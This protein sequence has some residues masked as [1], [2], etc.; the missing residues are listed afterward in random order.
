MYFL[1]IVYMGVVVYYVYILLNIII[2]KVVFCVIMLNIYFNL[3]N[4]MSFIIGCMENLLEG[5]CYWIVLVSLRV[6]MCK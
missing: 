6:M 3:I 5:R 2:I 1:F 4:K